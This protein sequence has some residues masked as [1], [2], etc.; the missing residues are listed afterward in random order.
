MNS[1]EIQRNI[2]LSSL[3]ILIAANS[4][5]GVAY[6]ITESI[7]RGFLVSMISYSIGIILLLKFKPAYWEQIKKEI[8]ILI[9]KK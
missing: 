9:N 2:I 7:L 4:L 8:K 3:I 6:A 1:E 5:G